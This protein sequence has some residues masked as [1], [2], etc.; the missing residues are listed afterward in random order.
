VDIQF[1]MSDYQYLEDVVTIK[2]MSQEI[3]KLD[4]KI[5]EA[6]SA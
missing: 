2:K 3:E 6:R 1:A 5:E 4:L